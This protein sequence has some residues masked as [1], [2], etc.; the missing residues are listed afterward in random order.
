[1]G[2]PLEVVASDV[3]SAAARLQ[4][5][6]QRLQDGLSGVDLETRE[7]LGSGW[8]GE[9]ASAFSSV[10]EQWHSGAGQIQPLAQAGQVAAGLAQVAAQVAQVAEQAAQA[11]ESAGT[12][13]ARLSVPCNRCRSCSP[14]PTFRSYP[15]TRVR[16]RS[17][18]LGVRSL[19]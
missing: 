4:E 2:Q 13:D 8:R 3:H 12:S 5:A 17:C 16:P 1:M 6:G 7:L 10:W 19:K 11:D 9:A 15:D 14:W 18:S